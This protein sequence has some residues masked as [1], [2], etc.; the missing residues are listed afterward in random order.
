MVTGK[1]NKVL[2]KI[3]KK[4]RKRK[5]KR[6]IGEDM[7][8]NKSA[9]ENTIPGKE[10]QIEAIVFGDGSRSGNCEL[11]DGVW[12]GTA[13]N[14]KNIRGYH[15]IDIETV[16]WWPL[17][18]RKLRFPTCEVTPSMWVGIPSTCE[19]NREAVLEFCKVFPGVAV[20]ISQG[21][22]NREANASLIQYKANGLVEPLK[23]A[24][25]LDC[26]PNAVVNAVLSLKGK[27][28]ALRV[29]KQL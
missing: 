4:K 18:E 27:E 23:E 24:K 17:T 1:G 25:G 26:V 10:W 22:G 12:Y 19:G 29:M 6:S 13:G 8:R 15:S 2:K 7:R 3:Q 21:P 20:M 28:N 9:G 5:K 16:T 11:R 14:C